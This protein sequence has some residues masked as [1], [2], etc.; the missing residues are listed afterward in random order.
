MKKFGKYS[1]FGFFEGLPYGNCDEDITQYKR[2]SVNIEPEIVL[3][4]IE[5]LDPAFTSEPTFDLF[6]G[7]EFQAGLYDDG[8]F[9][10]PTDFV[11]YFRQGKVD[12]PEE[13][14][15]YLLKELEIA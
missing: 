14:E 11:R 5:S 4:H 13:Y 9:V 1:A 15:N 7:E 2:S 8:L 3:R 6:S 10:F 12:I